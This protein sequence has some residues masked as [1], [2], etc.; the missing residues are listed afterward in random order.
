MQITSGTPSN[1]P[2]DT[3]E[4]NPASTKGNALA[5]SQRITEIDELNAAIGRMSQAV[6][7]ANYEL[8]L[9]IREFDERA[10]WYQ[11]GFTDGLS[12][13]KW[14]CDLGTGAARDKLRIAHALKELPLL[15]EAF[16]GGELSYTKVRALTRIATVDNEAELIVM[17]QR[18]TARHVEEHCKQRKNT[19]KASTA[20]AKQAQENRNYRIWRDEA[21]GTV[22]FS[23]ELAGDDAELIEKAVEKAAVQF[24][25]ET[26]TVARTPEEAESWAAHQVDGLVNVCR[27][28]LDGS[29]GESTDKPT[30][31]TKA[32]STADHYQVVVHIDEAALAGTETGTSQLPLES[33]RRLCCD[34]SMVP[35]VE[36]ESGEPLNVGRKVRTVTTAIK[37]A[38]WSRDKGCRFPGCAHT[39]FVDAHHIRHWAEGGETSVENMVLLCSSHHKLVHEGGYSIRRDQ[40]GDVFFS[41]PDGKAV[42]HCGFRIK[43]QL[44]PDS[45]FDSQGT[46]PVAAEYLKNSH[47]FFDA[48]FEHAAPSIKTHEDLNDIEETAGV[49]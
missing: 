25:S 43:D 42:P 26:G 34:G 19:Q 9:H 7:V 49:Y 33:V 36:N 8:I 44:A 27:S 12:W 21:R 5:A 29:T 10:G 38:L 23:I 2:R 20:L 40:A 39:R 6:N 22:R 41:R 45:G 17:A 48:S 18:M 28:Y 32:T 30:K 3:V 11:W 47:E 24:S 16:A 1:S 37:R 31:L 13:L 15:S 46:D 35:L 4:K 14:R